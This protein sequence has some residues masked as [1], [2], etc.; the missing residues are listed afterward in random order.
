MKSVKLKRTLSSVLAALGLMSALTP[1]AAA[2]PLSDPAK[3]D[4]WESVVAEFLDTYEDRNKS[5]SI[6]LGYRN[7]VTGEEHFYKGDEYMVTCS[8]YKVPLNMY[9]TEK[10]YNGEMDWDTLIAEVPYSE[11]IEGSIVRSSNTKSEMLIYA[12]GSYNDYRRAIC[13]YMGVD[14]DEVE[15]KYYEN[16]FFTAR[17]MIHCLGMLYEE[18]EHFPGVIERML[19]AEPDNYFNYHEQEFDVAHKYGY[20]SDR[21]NGKR[22]VNDC[23]IVY[24]DEPI[25]IVMFTDNIPDSYNALADYCT[26]MSNYAQA[27]KSV[28]KPPKDTSG[29]GPAPSPATT[30]APKASPAP[31]P[32]ATVKPSPAAILRPSPRPKASPSP[33]P[34]A[35]AQP[36]PSE[37][38]KPASAALSPSAAPAP[39]QSPTYDKGV[40][41]AQFALQYVGYN[42]KY[43]G[44]DPETGFDCS[45]LV[46]YTYG[47]FGYALDRTAEAQSRNGEHV[48]ADAMEPGDIICFYNGGNYIGHVGIYI[49][50]GE[51]VHAQSSATGVIVSELSDVSCKTEVRRILT[52]DSDE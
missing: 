52:A 50:N 20:L 49:G 5:C 37:T 4:D 33:R 18:Q 23:A 21:D 30:S 16:N 43:G 12:I 36:E 9:F 45:G 11:L 32:A 13:P 10:I 6:T 48:E 3:N 38:P 1:S 35:A 29:P 19:R 2:A 41:V 15:Y 25:A 31:S 14:P 24:T 34:G 8:M 22:Y 42:Y 46:Y 27:H 51:Y 28:T 39:T 40:E 44:K 17:Q 26:L 7:L 47:E